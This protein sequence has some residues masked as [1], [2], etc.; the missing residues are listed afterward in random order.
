MGVAPFGKATFAAAAAAA[1][2]LASG[3]LLL[4]ELRRNKKINWTWVEDERG[5]REQGGWSRVYL[6]SWDVCLSTLLS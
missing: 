4:T 5:G 1:F 2:L 3:L 6:E